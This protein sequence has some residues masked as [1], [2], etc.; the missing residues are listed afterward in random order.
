MSSRLCSSE[1]VTST[2]LRPLSQPASSHAHPLPS[3]TELSKDMHVC[4][5]R[6]MQP[7]HP[8]HVHRRSNGSHCSLGRT[9]AAIHGTHPPAG[10]H[11]TAARTCP[12]PVGHT[13][14]RAA[15]A[16]PP[17]AAGCWRPGPAAAA[18]AVRQPS[19]AAVAEALHV[20]SMPARQATSK[21]TE[22]IVHWRIRVQVSRACQQHLPRH[23]RGSTR[24][25]ALYAPAWQRHTGSSCIPPAAGP[26]GAGLASLTGSRPPPC[27]GPP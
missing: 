18:V 2:T 12:R 17:Y 23:S 6:R 9:P 1:G 24:P 5:M 22:A 20:S 11:A 10:C 13:P 14:A 16:A 15:Q 19:A 25:S 3:W 26:A 4:S 27:T 8:N 7:P 21:G